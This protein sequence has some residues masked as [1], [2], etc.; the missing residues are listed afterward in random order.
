[1]ASTPRWLAALRMPHLLGT[2][3]PPSR[4]ARCAWRRAHHHEEHRQLPAQARAAE[5][6]G[7]GRV[8]RG[9]RPSAAAAQIGA[10][11]A[12]ES[13]RRAR[14]A[15]RGP[16]PG[17]AQRSLAAGGLVPVTRV[18]R[19]RQSGLSPFHRV[20]CGCDFQR[21]ASLARPLPS[22][23]S[24]KAQ[25]CRLPSRCGVHNSTEYSRAEF[26]CQRGRLLVL[27]RRPAHHGC[28][29]DNAAIARTGKM[30]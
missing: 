20:A 19:A 18:N 24:A 8:A 16:A 12:T 29:P 2:M 13:P 6:R 21:E 9:G 7:F 30:A 17:R 23:S 14:Y 3:L 5:T 26:S 27:W 15:Q 25:A 10:M 1:M 22:L 4:S 28:S 11:V